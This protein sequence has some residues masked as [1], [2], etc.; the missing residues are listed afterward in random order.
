MSL[1][2]K[3]LRLLPKSAIK[4][5]LIQ[6]NSKFRSTETGSN[7]EN[8]QANFKAIQISTNPNKN[9]KISVTFQ[10]SK[11]STST[12]KDLKTLEHRK[13]MRDHLSAG[14]V[15]RRGRRGGLGGRVVARRVGHRDKKLAISLSAGHHDR[16]FVV[17]HHNTESD[18]VSII[19]NAQRPP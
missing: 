8:L 11:H 19:Q 5:N 15:R 14:V 18:A 17:A 12:I 2:F 13:K 6:N 1:T 3:A 16:R 4:E 7:L 10:G 9:S